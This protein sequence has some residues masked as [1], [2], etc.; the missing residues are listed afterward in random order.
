MDQRLERINVHVRPP[1]AVRYSGSVHVTG[2]DQESPLH[3][4]PSEAEVNSRARTGDPATPA[5]R[6]TDHVCPASVVA[7]SRPEVD[8][9]NHEVGDTKEGS[10]MG[11]PSP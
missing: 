11:D 9:M 4:H 6:K 2:P 8:H 5:G 3:A 1:S 7:A 10:K